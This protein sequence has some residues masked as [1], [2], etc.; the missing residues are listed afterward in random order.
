MKK[1]VLAALCCATSAVPAMAQHVHG[2]TCNHQTTDNQGALSANA[3]TSD[4]I[5]VKSDAGG[6]M[7]F[8]LN[9]LGGVEAGTDALKGFTAAAKLFSNFFKDDI[10]IRL[11][12]QFSQ[13]PPNVLGSTG[14]TTNQG[15]YTLIKTLLQNDAKTKYDAKAVAN[16]AGGAALSFVTNEPPVSG[17]IDSRT[18]FLDNNNS[19]DNLN[20]QINTAQVKALGLNPVYDAVGNPLGRD[21]TV[22]FSNQF[23]WD[24]DR[25]DGLDPTKIDFVGVAAHEIG[26][27]L[28][29]RSGVDLADINAAPGDATPARGLGNIAWGTVNDLFRYGSFDGQRTLDWSI[30]SPVCHSLDKGATCTGALSTGR[31]NG[32][33]RQ[34]SHWKDD[35][36]TNKLIGL[37]DP[38]ASGPG[39]IRPFQAITQAD[40]IAFD[41][42]GYDLNSVPEPATWAMM[43]AG[44]GFVGAAARRRQSKVAFA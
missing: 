36:L 7:K 2:P 34:A 26:H 6:G 37:M 18:R 5:V 30:N 25:S 28:G 32:D 23:N 42:M 21:G 38:T 22:S 4:S 43:I 39:G 33:L 10:T 41:A 3:L 44:F 20:I 11:D 27:A 19:F 40:L 29:F 16:L 14:S 13:L 8:V 9:N 12:V 31:L 24:F 35:T 17:V 1:L 15:P